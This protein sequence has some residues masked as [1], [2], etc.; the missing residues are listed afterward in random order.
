MSNED[1]TCDDEEIARCLSLSDADEAME[2]ERRRQKQVAA[3]ASLALRLTAEDACARLCDASSLALDAVIARAIAAKD[4]LA[5]IEAFAPK[6]NDAAV[7]ASPPSAEQRA[8]EVD[9]GRLELRLEFYGL[10]E[11][12]VTGDG[13]CQFRALSD[14]LFRDGGEYH[15]VVRAAVVERLLNRRDAYEA[16]VAPEAYDSYVTKMSQLGEWGD[17]VTLQAA[18]DAYSVTINVL[19]SYSEN[20]FIEILPSDGSSLNS[21]RSVWLSFFAEVH[22]NSIYPA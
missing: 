2:T 18:A 17:H 14:Q 1:V 5:N 19:T 12:N 8:Y 11:K 16:Y 4:A 3:D 9:H 22:Y 13:N 7:I 21:P 10:R 6:T 20:G 15:D